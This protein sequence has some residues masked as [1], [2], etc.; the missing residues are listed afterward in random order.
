MARSFNNNNKKV[1]NGQWKIPLLAI[2]DKK[3][4]F[5]E[6]IDVAISAKKKRQLMV[7]R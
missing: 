3:H 6:F 1:R 4:F 7:I 5:I 2:D